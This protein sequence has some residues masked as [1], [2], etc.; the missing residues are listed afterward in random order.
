MDGIGCEELLGGES[1]SV[2]GMNKT[3][4]VETYKFDGPTYIPGLV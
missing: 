2:A 1:I 3:G 4:H